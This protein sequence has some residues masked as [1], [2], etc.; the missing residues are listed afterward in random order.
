MPP[1]IAQLL[2]PFFL[3][4][5]STRCSPIGVEERAVLVDNVADLEESYEYVI[6][7][8]GTGGLTAA[9][10]ILIVPPLKINRAC[11]ACADCC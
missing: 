6:I 9:Y 8:G 4:A 1:S 11:G 5:A 2:L 7:G 3:F 10:R